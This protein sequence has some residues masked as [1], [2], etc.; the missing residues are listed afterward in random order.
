MYKHMLNAES[1]QKLE[2]MK[3][4]TFKLLFGRRGRKTRYTLSVNSRLETTLVSMSD[5]VVAESPAAPAAKTTKKAPK[6][7]KAKTKK[8]VTHP[9]Y[10]I[11]ISE[12]IK[13]LKERSGS[14][15]QAIVK[16]IVSNYKIDEKTANTQVKLSLKREVESGS[17]KQVKGVGASGSF[18]LS[19]GDE[20]SKPKKVVA[21]KPAAKK[22]AKKSAEK[23]TPKK[24][25]V[26]KSTVA[27]KS[28]AKK[29]KS[30]KRSPVKKSTKKAA[31][32]KKPA[33]KKSKK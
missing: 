1:T 9:K 23:K 6:E 27:K 17:L 19:K 11:M 28:P 31:K 33:A 4:R 30:T 20:E 21:K 2:R 14:S 15:R 12:A 24:K 8:T 22:P 25:A 3:S 18:K 26:K 16:Y 7:K 29:T 5:A 13:A 32:P 10:I